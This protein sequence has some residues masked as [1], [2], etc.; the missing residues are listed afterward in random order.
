S[1]WLVLGGVQFQPSE[2]AKVA[3]VIGLAMLLGEVRDGEDGPRNLD[4]V[5]ALA[6]A[7]VPMGLILLQP[8]LGTALVLGVVFL[9]MVS[10]SGAPRRWIV[11]LVLG[12]VLAAVAAVQFHLLEPYQM[13][14][15][16]AFADPSAGPR[17]VTY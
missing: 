4:V 14:R 2:F 6:L 3:L 11:G 15:F 16:V 7:A 5:Q 8:D 12:V 13:A 9:G 1:S 10:V 17:G